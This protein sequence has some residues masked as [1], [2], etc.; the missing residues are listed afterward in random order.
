M[1]LPICLICL[2]PTLLVGQSMGK[3]ARTC[4]ILFAGAPADGPEKIHL[5]NGSSSQEVELPRMNLSPV[6]QLPSGPLVVTL[7]PTPTSKPKDVNPEAPHA[8]IDAGITDVY[9]LVTSDP[10]NEIAPVK[11]QVINANPK[12]GAKGQMT[13]CNLTVNTVTGTI[14]D[15]KLSLDPHAEVVLSLRGSKVE[16]LPVALTYRMPDK[17]ADYPLIETK[18]NLGGLIDNYLAVVVDSG[19]RVPRVTAFPDHRE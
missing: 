3:D 17:E 14:G 7:S 12:K 16:D 6:Y 2:I 15:Q 9:L 18:W 4:R 1:N 10:T 8:T 5:F 13:W 19:T 11:L